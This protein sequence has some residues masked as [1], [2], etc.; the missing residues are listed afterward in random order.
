MFSGVEGSGA[1]PMALAFAAYVLCENPAEDRCGT[2]PA[3]KQVD[4]LAHPD[5]H[6]SFP[7]PR[8]LQTAD[9]L[10]AEF[11][12]AV[13]SNPYLSLQEWQQKIGEDKLPGI[14]IDEAH[15]IQKCLSLKSFSGGHKIILIWMAENMNRETAN[16]LLKTLEEPTPRTL[17]ILVVEQPDKLLPTVLSRVQRVHCPPLSDEE[18]AEGLARGNNVSSAQA[19][20]LAKMAGGSFQKALAI[21]S[22]NEIRKEYFGLFSNWMR[23]TYKPDFGQIFKLGDAFQGLRRDGQ[24]RFLE[25]ALDFVHKCMRLEHL[26]QSY[27]D[28]ESRQF[29]ERFA[30]FLAAGDLSQLHDSMSEAHYHIERNANAHLLFT[31]LSLKLMRYFSAVKKQ[32]KAAAEK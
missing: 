23:H 2:C 10:H 4:H 27:F 30:P 1:L 28:A 5:L 26:G 6:L 17:I 11:V 16:N 21:L 9:R 3:C 19:A 22:E 7:Y 12:E 29:A 18:V 15:R 32:S 8:K 20:D 31:S 14:F 24:M 25:F 13:S